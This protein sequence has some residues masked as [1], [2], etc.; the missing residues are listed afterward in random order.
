MIRQ[1][2]HFPGGK[3]LTRNAAAQIVQV[4]ARFSCRLMIEREQKIINAKSMLGLLS[5]GL[6][7]N[8]PMTLLAD[9][10]D[11]AE[12]VAAIQQLLDAEA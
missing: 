6:D 8:K 4:T 12:A 9:G 1:P 2:I 3:P 7:A 10:V 5:L 11:E